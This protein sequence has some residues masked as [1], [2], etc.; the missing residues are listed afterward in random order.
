MKKPEPEAMTVETAGMCPFCGLQWAAGYDPDGTYAVV[1]GM[2]S[3][4]DFQ[5]FEPE[6][7]LARV[8][9]AYSKRV[10]A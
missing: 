6:D 4:S 1:H 2:P 10:S 5:K 9:K 8:R 3:C 7:F